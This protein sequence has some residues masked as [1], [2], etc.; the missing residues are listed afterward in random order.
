MEVQ[1]EEEKLNRIESNRI[2][3]MTM[4][5]ENFLYLVG[6]VDACTPS[7]LNDLQLTHWISLTHP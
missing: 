7:L 4:V 3:A 1:V 2:G 6:M 5:I